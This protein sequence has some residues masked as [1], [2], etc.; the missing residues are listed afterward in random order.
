MPE[1]A[2]WIGLPDAVHRA[3]GR[4]TRWTAYAAAMDGRIESRR[5]GRTWEVRVDSLDQYV[6]ELRARESAQLATT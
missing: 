2:K 6:R 1:S 5:R 3:R 4:L